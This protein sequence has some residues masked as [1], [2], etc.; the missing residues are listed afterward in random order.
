MP[1]I[2]IEYTANLEPELRLAALIEALHEVAAGIEA[3][4][5]AGLRTR[6]ERR[7]DYRIADGHADNAFV[8]VSLRIA[9]GRPLEVR[10]AA[11]DALF[12]ALCRELQPLIDTRPLALSFEISEIDAQLNYKA[13]NIRDYMARRGTA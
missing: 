10:K 8:H 1:H 11:G 3:F 9:H 7:D 6:A 12:E 5:V 2:T 4:P 13:G